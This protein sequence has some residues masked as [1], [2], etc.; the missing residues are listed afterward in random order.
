LSEVRRRSNL[1]PRVAVART[2]SERTTC[3]E[4]GGGRNTFVNAADE[5]RRVKLLDCTV[6]ELDQLVIDEGAT[7][8]PPAA[9]N[10]GFKRLLS[11]L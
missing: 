7:S 1:C 11:S 8:V 3:A 10:D 6:I 9:S 5:V 4:E 2:W